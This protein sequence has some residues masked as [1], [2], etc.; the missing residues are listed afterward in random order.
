MRGLNRRK[1]AV[2]VRLGIVGLLVTDRTADVNFWLL[3]HM[4]GVTIRAM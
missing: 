2:G 1:S 4:H 3:A